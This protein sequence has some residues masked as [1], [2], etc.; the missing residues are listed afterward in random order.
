[1]VGWIGGRRGGGRK[2]GREGER[3]REVKEISNNDREQA[4]IGGK[5]EGRTTLPASGARRWRN[6]ESGSLTAGSALS[7]LGLV[8]F[9]RRVGC[10]APPPWS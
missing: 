6:R 2:G 4:E 8:I 10:T 3:G 9:S 7:L 5:S 1:M